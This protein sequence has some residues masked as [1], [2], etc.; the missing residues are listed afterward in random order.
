MLSEESKKNENEKSIWITAIG[1][2]GFFIVFIVGGILSD[3]GSP[4][5]PIII[6]FGLVLFIY[7]IF[8]FIGN[9]RFVKTMGGE[10]GS[11]IAFSI[12]IATLIIESNRQ[13]SIEINSVFG[14][15]ASAFSGTQNIMTILKT[16]ILSKILLSV[17]TVWGGLAFIYYL[18]TGGAGT[19]KSFQTFIFAISGLIIG[20]IGWLLIE[21]KLSE[22]IVHK[23]IYLVAHSF[24]FNANVKCPGQEINGAAVFL[25]QAQ[26]RVFVDESES[27][28]MNW[29]Q[30]LYANPE[31]LSSV[32]L[33]T[34][35]NLK[36][37]TCN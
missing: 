31:E 32:A 35:E 9:T 19:H 12:L 6:G 24:D 27:P 14:I 7:Y 26:N 1:S 29:L 18:V 37:Y 17:F 34:S 3:S 22:E 10:W 25:G 11:K 21:T 5:T 2:L 20:G 16:F 30:A 23:K 15:A 13:V 4:Y 28:K 8:L 36:I 33:P